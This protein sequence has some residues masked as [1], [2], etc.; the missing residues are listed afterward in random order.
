MSKIGDLIEKDIDQLIRND[1]R[2]PK[3]LKQILWLVLFAFLITTIIGAILMALFLSSSNDTQDRIK[4]LENAMQRG[5]Y[6]A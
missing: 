1:S 3:I 2:T 6:S 5:I 4:I